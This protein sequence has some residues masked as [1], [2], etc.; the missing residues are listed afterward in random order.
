[1]GTL[2]GTAFMVLLPESM[3]WLSVALRGSPIDKALALKNNIAFLREMAIGL[4]IIVVSDVRAG[5]TRASLAADQGVLETLPVLAL[6]SERDGQ[7]Q[8][9]EK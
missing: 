8:D 3:E 5:R 7:Q 4:I 6:R 2:M 1:M 9:L